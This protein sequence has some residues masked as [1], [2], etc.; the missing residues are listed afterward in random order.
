M[1]I[2]LTRY[3]SVNGFT[4]EQLNLMRAFD[5][6]YWQGTPLFPLYQRQANLRNR[7]RLYTL[8]SMDYSRSKLII[9]GNTDYETERI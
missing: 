1:V 9:N 4:D 2:G 6:Y 3:K 5:N 7:G 8:V